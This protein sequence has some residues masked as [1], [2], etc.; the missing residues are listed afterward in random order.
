ML[1]SRRNARYGRPDRE[2]IGQCVETVHIRRAA[3]R[4]PR[5]VQKGL[6]G[7]E[8]AALLDQ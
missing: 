4:L 3:V 5:A 7:N 2:K 1:R 8:N 6:D